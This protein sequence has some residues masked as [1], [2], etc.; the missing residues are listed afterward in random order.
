[1]NLLLMDIDNTKSWKNTRPKVVHVYLDLKVNIF[2]DRDYNGYFGVIGYADS[3]YDIVNIICCCLCRI[4]K[5]CSYFITNISP[6]DAQRPGC[7]NKYSH[8]CSTSSTY[9]N[10]IE[11]N[12]TYLQPFILFHYN[13]INS[14]IN[15]VLCT[16]D[17]Q[18]D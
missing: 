6:L 4:I 17:M 1:M 11:M 13:R 16:Q 8:T 10:Y 9:Y 5:Q 7:D 2:E 12:N 14:S 3:K 18:V 15:V